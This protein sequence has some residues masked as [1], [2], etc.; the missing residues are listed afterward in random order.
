MKRQLIALSLVAGFLAG[1]APAKE[2]FI[3]NE[4]AQTTG[5]TTT[6]SSD[7]T[8]PPIQ[9]PNFP[10]TPQGGIGKETTQ[11]SYTEGDTTI[12]KV[13]MTMPIASIVGDETL[14][15]TLESRLALVETQLQ[16]EI[17]QLYRRYLQ[18]YQAGKTGITVPSVMIR[19]QLNYF[20]AEAASMTYIFSE[21]TWDGLVYTHLYHS[22]LD[23]RVGSTMQLSAL[24]TDGMLSGMESIIA[25]KLTEQAV[26][27]QYENALQIIMDDL[28]SAWYILPGYL[29]IHM[30]SGK[31]API[32]SGEVV[33][34]FSEEELSHLLSDYGKA[35][36]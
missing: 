29:Q 23:L 16:K 13:S 7:E 3:T 18:D 19:F 11:Y 27:G 2:P 8:L 25:K 31:I 33:L 15:A 6:E 12:L 20:T 34:S 9:P 32:S 35:L 28:D 10:N 17:D 14:Q 36:L 21:T 22:N 4:T 26:D 1:C 30:E 5:V 24:L